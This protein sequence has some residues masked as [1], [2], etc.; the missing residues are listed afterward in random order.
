M[1]RTAIE[2]W[3]EAL[4][5]CGL[6]LAQ[7]DASGRPRIAFGAPLAATAEGEA[8]LAEIFLAERVPAWRIR[9]A[10]AERL[11]ASHTLLSAEDVW[12]GAPPLPG[13]VT[14]A[15]WHVE[16]EPAG[17]DPGE[18]RVVAERLLGSPSLPRTRSKGGSDKPYDLRPLLDDVEVSQPA[19]PGEAA[20]LRIRTRFHPELGSGRPE[21]VVAALAEALGSELVVRRIVRKRLLLI[22]DVPS[23][24]RP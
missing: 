3:Q 8:E 6:A 11:P 2:A 7:L 18:L 13:R 5:G 9:E 10:L 16:L 4:I 20:S 14:A 22:E 1:G 17:I 24:T 15:D 21:E 12:L 23:R 19:G